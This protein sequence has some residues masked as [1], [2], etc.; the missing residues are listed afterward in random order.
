M[1]QRVRHR[2]ENDERPVAR[3]VAAPGVERAAGTDTDAV[4]NL[5]QLAGNRA[6]G[7]LLRGAGP[8]SLRPAVQRDPGDDATTVGDPGALPLTEVANAT[9]KTM[10]VPD[11]DLVLPITSFGM[12]AQPPGAQGGTGSRAKEMSV[13]MAAESLDPRISNAVMTGAT[14]VLSSGS[15]PALTLRDVTMT[16]L[17]TGGASASFTLSFGSAAYAT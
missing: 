3:T 15:G 16:S 11:L 4:L 7:E 1:S 10:S 6:V 8:D 14:V 2:D 13:T 12:P 9:S 5:Q 17:N